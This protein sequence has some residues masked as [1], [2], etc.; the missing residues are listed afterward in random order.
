LR[1]WRQDKCSEIAFEC[2]L[3]RS[4]STVDGR[5]YNSIMTESSALMTP[6]LAEAAIL[7]RMT[8]LSAES[9]P[10]RQ[11][12]GA[13]LRE[14]VHAERDNP[15]F[16]RVALD[17]IAVSS[18]ALHH[19][20][21]RFRIQG[22]QAAG[23]PA[24]RLQEGDN[25]IEVMTGAVLPHSSDCV[26]PYEQYELERGVAR[27]TA[28]VKSNPFHNVHRRGSDGAKGA[29]LLKLGT[30]L[31]PV[32][33]AVA[34]AAGRPRLQVSRQPAIMIISTGDE[35]I[36][37]GEPIAEHQVR[38]SNAYGVMAALRARGFTRVGDDHLLDDES[39]LEERL[40][41]HLTTHDVVILSGG[42]SMGRF[43]LVPKALTKLGVEQVFHKV[44]QRPGKPL[45]FGIGTRGQ[46]VFGLPGNP[47]STLVCLLRYVIPAIDAARGA[48]PAPG[49]NVALA[50]EVAFDLPLTH[51]LPVAILHDEL[52][53]PWAHARPTNGSGDFVS[54][55]GTN[56]F[57]ELAPGPI[58][59]PKG[60]I[61]RLYRW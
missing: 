54:L 27:L 61:A 57:V 33:I 15:P 47:V 5:R 16:D 18:D 20:T 21:T 38:R 56:G 60:H 2:N 19:G 53:T 30:Q 41:L 9:L 11:C 50:D 45:W 37:P 32:H 58:R 24:S 8:P 36:E 10:L 44:A 35:L 25:A 1:A 17:G 22:T 29:L 14:D 40:A 3:R 13:T 7:A 26:V 4:A 6:A 59:H 48:T 12:A 49:E 42:V 39:L 52:G 51:F 28:R 55:I 31:R 23:A 34:A 46:S 43:D